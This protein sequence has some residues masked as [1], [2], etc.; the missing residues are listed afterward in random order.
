MID[1]LPPGLLIILGAFLLPITQGVVRYALALI[2]PLLALYLVWQVPDGAAVTLHFL[3]YELTPLRGEPIGR[4]FATVFAIMVA[5]GSLF[6]LRSAKVLELASAYLYAGSAMGVVMAGDLITVFVYWELMAI[7]STLIVWA[8]GTATAYQASMR[9]AVVHLFGGVVL[10]VGIVGQVTLT[11]DVAFRAMELDSLWTWMILVGFLVNAGAP[12]FSSWL[13]DAYPEASPS[14]MVFMSAFTTKT[15]IYVLLQGFAG[16]DILIY[17]GLFM[18]VY[19]IVYALLEN[20]M[21]RLLAYSIINQVGFMVVGV[22]IGTEMAINGV[23]TL[24]FA[25]IIYKA[26]LLMAAGSVMQMTGKRKLTDLG[27]LFQSMP[28][29]CACALVGALASLAFPLTAGFVSKSMITTAASDGQMAFAWFM[30][31]AASG[32]VVLHS[33]L[34]FPWFVFFHRDSGL[35]PPEPPIDMRFA[36]VILAGLCVV[37][38][39]FPQPLY[40]ALPFAVDYAPYKGSNILKALQLVLFPALAFFLLLPWMQKTHTITLDFDWFY[41]RFGVWAVRIGDAVVAGVRAAVLGVASSII[42]GAMTLAERVAGSGAPLARHR[43]AGAM[44]IWAM[45]LLGIYLVITL[46]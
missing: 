24:A 46:I 13:P 40:E 12:P 22:G 28:L 6:A 9:Y 44:S 35:R 4:I 41:R 3:D 11:G 14:G 38:G 19:G 21:R 16:A 2:L 29:T 17:V 25:H 5:V 20:D 37:V 45:V 27:G 10:M 42:S 30:L 36:M 33:G 43:S 18:V 23:V 26:L 34:K 31:I 32:A 7:G 1:A 8:S 15:A 39:I